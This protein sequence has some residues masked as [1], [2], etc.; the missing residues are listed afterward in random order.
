MES[1]SI[2]LVAIG[3][4]GNNYVKALLQ[5]GDNYGIEIVGAVDPY[6]ESCINLEELKRRKIPIFSDLEEFYKIKK[7][8]L[9]V[10]SSPIHFHCKQTITALENGSNVL[11]EKPAAATIQEIY[12]MIET[13]DRTQLKVAIGFQWAYDQAYISLKNDVM[14]GLLGKPKRLKTLVLWPR[15]MAYYR[16]SNWAGRKMDNNGNWILDSV[17]NNATAHFLH[18]MLHLLGKSIESSTRPIEVTAE[19]YKAN[20]IENFDTSAIRVLT[21]DRVEILFYATHAVRNQVGPIF[22]YEFES[23]IVAYN[24]PTIPESTNKLIARFKD[25]NIKDYGSPNH[26]SVRKLWKTIDAIRGKDIVYCPLES[27]MA[28]TL[29]IN[30]AQE[31]TPE[32][33]DFPEEIIRREGDP[34]LNWVEGLEETLKYCYR[35]GIL[36]S[37]TNV[38]W[39]KPG[40]KISLIDYIK[41]PTR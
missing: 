35:E 12:R 19:L 13:R 26:S 32:I 15:N 22:I 33:I 8:N 28:H 41:F 14:K 27:A 39:A 18:N 36:P 11:C 29:T 7:A 20:P 2:V 31:S 24:E 17:A 1:L 3:G 9:A 21:E 38:S 16:R 34:V 23:A 6:P 5:E 25:G 37:E 40:K 4:Y 30:G 10:I